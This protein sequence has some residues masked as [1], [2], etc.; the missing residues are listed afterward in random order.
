[1]FSEVLLEFEEKKLTLPAL[2]SNFIVVQE[3]GD[4]PLQESHLQANVTQPFG[5]TKVLEAYVTN[6]TTIAEGEDVKT[7]HDVTLKCLNDPG[8]RY[9]PGDT[10]GILS[11]NTNSDVEFILDRLDLHSQCDNVCNVGIDP[12]TTKKGAKLP[13]FVPSVVNYRRLFKEC[14]DL[15]A[16]PKKLLI[17]SL[18]TC[19]TVEND[20]R[21]LEILCS[22]E[23]NSAYERY[24]QQLHGKGIIS[25]L[26]LVPSCRPTAAIL[27]AH[28]P[29]LMPRPY[30]IANTYREGGDSPAVRFLFSHDA[31]NPGITTTYLRGLEKGEKVYFYFRQSSAFVY[32]DTDLRCNIVMVGTGTGMSPY[33]SFL[34]RRADALAKGETLGRAELFVGFR[35]RERNYLCRDEI[36]EH[37]KMGVLDA[38]YEAFSRDTE[39][40]HKYVQ[41]QMQAKRAEIIANIRN[42]HALF[43][44]CG[45]AK[46][47]LPQITDTVV[48]ILAEAS[49]TEEEDMKTFV[50]GLKKDGKYREDV[51]L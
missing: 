7:V 5:V 29:R 28:L 6:S 46:V 42:P 16:V 13:L 34:E 39:T 14:L 24:V 32:K 25:L 8:H 26:E 51:W 17:R 18:T 47:L 48:N 45:D 36:K 44:V 19:T 37:L 49:E 40:Q 41:S 30:S 21:F 43:Y 20:R 35:Y 38:C 3:T 23:G 4:V 15:H 2:P 31:N 27:I 12:N 10:I 9:W 33:L 22:K 11:Y 50:D 1:M